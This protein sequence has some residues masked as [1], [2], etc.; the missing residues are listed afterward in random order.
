MRSTP[1]LLAQGIPAWSA[2]FQ[3]Q[4]A[5][6]PTSCASSALPIKQK[7]RVTPQIDSRG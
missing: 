4:S 5:R 3:V 1:Y 6:K 7:T 2:Q